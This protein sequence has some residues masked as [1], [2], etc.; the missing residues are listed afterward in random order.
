MACKNPTP[1]G[2]ALSI[3]RSPGCLMEGRVRVGIA[4]VDCALARLV[5]ATP[6]SKHTVLV[7]DDPTVLMPCVCP[8]SL[9][10]GLL[11]RAPPPAKSRPRL[12]IDLE[13]RPL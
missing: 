2:T 12:D 5:F 4:T 1:E 3:Y 13:R 9:G 6:T 11:V 8:P 10:H 7:F